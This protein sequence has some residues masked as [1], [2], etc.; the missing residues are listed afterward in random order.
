MAT[1]E[2][3][4]PDAVLDPF[5]LPTMC[6][7]AMAASK[8]WIASPDH[9]TPLGFPGELVPDWKEKAIDKMGELLTKYR[10]LRVYLDS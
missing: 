10:S 1:I 9:Q 2:T 4:A 6:P 7:G 3:P 5:E 8:P